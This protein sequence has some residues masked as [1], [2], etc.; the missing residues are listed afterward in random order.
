[1][2]PENCGICLEKL[3]LETVVDKLIC[4]HSFHCDCIHPWLDKSDT[5]PMC[6][7]TDVHRALTEPR[8]D[9]SQYRPYIPKPRRIRRITTA[10][11]RKVIILT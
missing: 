11:G 5:C 6:R 2:D 7:M 8:V 1:M 4:G 3:S 10:T 9:W